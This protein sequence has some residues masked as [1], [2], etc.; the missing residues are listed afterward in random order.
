ML[1]ACKQSDTVWGVHEK[2][3]E[4]GILKLHSTTDNMVI[5][6]REVTMQATSK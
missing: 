3:A 1:N 5:L 6:V 2:N 4:D